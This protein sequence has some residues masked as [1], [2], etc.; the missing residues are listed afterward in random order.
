MISGFRSE[1]AEN[2]SLLGYYAAISGNFLPT[3]RDNLSVSSSGFK[4]PKTRPVTTKLSSYREE[5][6]GGDTPKSWGDNKGVASG[7]MEVLFLRVTST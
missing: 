7:W 6:V 3:F 2:S 1:V 5:C 4:N